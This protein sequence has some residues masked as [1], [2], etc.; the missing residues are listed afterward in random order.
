MPFINIVP[1]QEQISGVLKGS[2]ALGKNATL[3]GE[4]IWTKNTL[5]VVLSPT[6]LTGLSMPSTNPFYPGGSGGT[7]INPA[8]PA[9][10]PANPVSLGWRTT[11][12][13]GARRVSRT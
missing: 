3:F 12:A 2:V 8:T 5:D 1:E 13:G 10:N 9:P 6:P 4:I 7:P 11:L